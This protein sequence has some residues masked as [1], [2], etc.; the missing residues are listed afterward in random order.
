MKDNLTKQG[1]ADRFLFD[2][3]TAAPIPKILD[4]FMPIKHVIN[5]SVVFPPMYE[6]KVIQDGQEFMLS[7]ELGSE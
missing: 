3:P 2:R 6:L 4:E 7:I 1:I 5:D